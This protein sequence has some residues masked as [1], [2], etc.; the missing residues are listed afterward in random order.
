M[1]RRYPHSLALSLLG[2]FARLT[3]AGERDAGK[4]RGH[5]DEEDEKFHF[6]GL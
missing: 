3:R 1:E 6:A 4:E 5:D 2:V